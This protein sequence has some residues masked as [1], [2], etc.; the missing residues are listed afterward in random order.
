M[1][2]LIFDIGIIRTLI[3]L[4]IMVI[5]FLEKARGD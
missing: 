2:G 1:Q 5:L 3:L 4:V